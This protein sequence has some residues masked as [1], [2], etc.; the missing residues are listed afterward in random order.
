M[1]AGFPAHFRAFPLLGRPRAPHPLPTAPQPPAA[2]PSA[3]CGAGAAAWGAEGSPRPP[4]CCSRSVMSGCYRSGREWDRCAPG[5][6]DAGRIR[7][8]R[9]PTGRKPPPPPSLFL[10]SGG[11]QFLHAR[12][13]L[14]THSGASK[15]A[16]P[17]QP[18]R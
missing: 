7:A 1:A 9:S 12:K 8:L 18:A 16:A 6:G 10:G 11:S 2:V 15:A 3:W 13:N 17:S 14:E 5:G 4:L